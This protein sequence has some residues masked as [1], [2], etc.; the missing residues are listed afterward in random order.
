VT[1]FGSLARDTFLIFIPEDKSSVI[2]F[3]SL[4]LVAIASL[5]KTATDHRLLLELEGIID[6]FNEIFL[7]AE[8]N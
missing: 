1:T 3:E 8:P 4:R 5:S 7:L 6:L 2:S